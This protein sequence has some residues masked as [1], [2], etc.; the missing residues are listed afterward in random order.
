MDATTVF[1]G[2]GYTF[3]GAS[4]ILELENVAN[5]SLG[6]TQRIAGNDSLG[7]A[8]DLR[9]GGSPAPAPQRELSAFW[10]HRIDR[11]WRT[12][13]YVMK[14]FAAGSP[15]WGAGIAAAYAF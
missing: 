12:H 9:Q 5:G 1:A 15:D 10:I 8:F 11:S 14:G 7:L 6:L 13:A 2:V 3:F 4:P